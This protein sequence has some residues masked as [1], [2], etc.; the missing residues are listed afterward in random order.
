MATPARSKYYWMCQSEFCRCRLFFFVSSFFF[1]LGA[2]VRCRCTHVHVHCTPIYVYTEQQN[3]MI[4]LVPVQSWCIL[5]SIMGK[6]GW[7]YYTR[8]RCG[9][10]WCLMLPYSALYARY[11]KIRFHKR[12]KNISTCERLTLTF[13]FG[14]IFHTSNSLFF[15]NIA[16]GWSGWVCAEAV[17]VLTFI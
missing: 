2:L 1:G 5:Y 13:G 12:Y 9:S 14:N 7:F 11:P 15:R 17:C 10:V 4:S 6:M 16:W 3:G 8:W